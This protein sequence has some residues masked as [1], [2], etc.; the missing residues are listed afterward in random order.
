MTHK[1]SYHEYK[2]FIDSAEKMTDRRESLNKNSRY[3][4]TI[5]IGAI[6]VIWKSAL[7]NPTLLF[8]GG[9]L[10]T[11]LCLISGVFCALWREEIIK[12]KKINAAKFDV[13]NKMAPHVDFDVKPPFSRIVSYE[14]FSKEWDI[15]SKGREVKKSD[16]LPDLLSFQS[17]TME[18]YVVMAFTFMFCLVGNASLIFVLS[19][20]S[21]LFTEIEKLLHL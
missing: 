17:T 14:P 18:I 13:I 4:C 15:L 5:I 9:A 12:Y 3:L 16:F 1:Y 21:G 8:V 19:K 7:T 11:L 10:A 2:M 20:Y 6:A